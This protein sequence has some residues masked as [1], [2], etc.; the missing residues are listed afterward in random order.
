MAQ[1]RIIEKDTREYTK[2]VAV[3]EML[4]A[5]SPNGFSYTVDEIYFDFGQDWWW[6]TIVANRQ[7]G[8]LWDSWQ[9]LSPRQWERILMSETPQEIAEAVEDVMNGKYNPDK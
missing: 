8:K 1:P 4:E 9:A 3:A 6:T 5:F 7:N 2:L